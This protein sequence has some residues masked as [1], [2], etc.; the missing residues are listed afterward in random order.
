MHGGADA[1]IFDRVMS[2]RGQEHLLSAGDSTVTLCV[3]VEN[4]E[5]ENN[6]GMDSRTLVL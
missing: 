6:W 5:K 3:Q 4:W 1:S 2:G